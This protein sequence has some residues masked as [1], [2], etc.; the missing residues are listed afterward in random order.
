M[1]SAVPLFKPD[2]QSLLAAREF[3]EHDAGTDIEVR[4]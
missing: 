1:A 2:E 4:S 3:A